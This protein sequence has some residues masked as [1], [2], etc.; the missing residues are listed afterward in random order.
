VS[1]PDS[2]IDL[3]ERVYEAAF[4]AGKWPSLLQSLQRRFGGPATLRLREI[5][6]DAVGLMLVEGQDPAFAASFREY[7]C[8][9]NP[10]IGAAKHLPAP[11]LRRSHELVDQDALE[12]SEFYNDWLRPQDAYFGMGAVLSRSHQW[13][14]IVGVIRPKRAGPFSVTEAGLLRRFLPHLKRAIVI[15]RRLGTA[16]LERRLGL[17]VMEA[18]S[19]GVLLL[20]RTGRMLFANA[21]AQGLL[22]E[23][24]AITAAG[25]RLRAATRQ[26][27]ARLETLVR[28]AAAIDAQET[29]MAGG[30][31]ALP[32]GDRS[33]ALSILVC[34]Y[35]RAEPD[36]DLVEPAV[37]V[38]IGRRRPLRILPPAITRLY[39]LSPAEAD[40]AGAIIAGSTPA[41]HAHRSRIAAETARGY[42]KS[43]FVKTGTGRQSA[44]VAALLA[45]P[46]LR[47]ARGRVH[48]RQAR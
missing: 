39:G 30:M 41:E 35:R 19:V 46:I 40:L 16:A 15:R 47:L 18:L 27:A 12:R 4:D 2:L 11:C 7:Y 3:V 22:S 33:E 13:E 20:D 5:G 38:F 28:N 25:S 32:N 6:S 45:D 31:M 34:P 26:G 24:D 37:V 23:G 42:L 48:R 14:T 21:V 29:E 9:L 10:W 43:I 44:L 8:K 17:E 36:I 1:D